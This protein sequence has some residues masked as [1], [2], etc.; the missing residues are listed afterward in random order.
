MQWAEDAFYAAYHEAWDFDG[1][2]AVSESLATYKMSILVTEASSRMTNLV[3]NV[4]N[5]V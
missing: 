1:L 3:F 4:G 2:K 5:A